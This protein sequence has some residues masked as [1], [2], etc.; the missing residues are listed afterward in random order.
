MTRLQKRR[1]RRVTA[2]AAFLLLLITAGIVV[3]W[4]MP[5]KKVED[6]VFEEQVKEVFE[7]SLVNAVDFPIRTYYRDDI[8]LDIETQA[9]LYRACAEW[10][11]PYELALAICWRETNYTHRVT[12]LEH[13]GVTRH[14]YGMMA[15]Q[16]ESAGWYMELCDVEDLNSVENSLRVGCCILSQHRQEYGNDFDALCRYCVE[17]EGWYAKDVLQYMMNL[18]E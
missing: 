1:Q 2:M 10:N 15:V 12:V 16:L 14:Y 7:Q 6:E 5:D 13:N 4:A 3:V 8:P 17:Y 9:I 18:L 11:V